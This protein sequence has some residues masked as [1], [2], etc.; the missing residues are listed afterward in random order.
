MH[1]PADPGEIIKKLRGTIP[2][3]VSARRA[4]PLVVPLEKSSGKT[5]GNSDVQLTVHGVRSQADSH[6]TSIELSIKSTGPETSSGGDPDAYNAVLERTGHQQL[7]I[8]VLDASGRLI[9]WFPSVAD[10]ENSH[11]TLTLTSPIVSAPIKE[12]RYYSLART[13]VDIPFEFADVPMP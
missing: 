4:N 1:R 6:N 11:V 13:E 8:D 12:L 10:I 2:V 3:T 7:Q 9:P 5:F